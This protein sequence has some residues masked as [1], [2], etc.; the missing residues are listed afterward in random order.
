MPSKE[1]YTLARDYQECEPEKVFSENDLFAVEMLDGTPCYVSIVE[2]ALAG[3]LGKKGLSAYLRLCLQDPEAPALT[4]TELENSQECYLVTL[5]NSK[6]DLE[7]KELEELTSFDLPFAENAFPQFR[8]KRQ[9]LFPWYLQKDDEENLLRLLKAIM[10]AKNYFA[11]FGKETREASLNPWLESLGL[12]AIETTEYVPY[13]QAEGDTF[14]VT[15]KVLPDDAYSIE[16]PQA[17]IED[18]ALLEQFKLIKAKPGKVLYYAT[19]LFPD[20]VMSAKIPAPVFPVVEMLYD[21][22]KH[23]LLDVFMVEDYEEG[24]V[25][26]VSR[27]LNYIQQNGKPQAIHCFGDRSFPLLNALC[28]QLGIRLMQGTFNQELESLKE[29]FVLQG[30][31]Q[32]GEEPGHEHVHDHTC[33]HHHHSH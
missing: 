23:D 30:R 14:S 33:E 4:L 5:N 24:H 6:E 2:G 27:L 19:F 29:F 26:L 8:I 10:F 17:E 13:L 20:P 28:K 3:Y 31:E 9:Y 11:K 16:F 1:L 21:P 7:E 25:G 15:A 18:P 22:Q 12:E 32:E